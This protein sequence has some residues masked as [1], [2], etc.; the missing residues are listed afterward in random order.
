MRYMMMRKADANTEQGM[1]P[2]NE[3]LSDMGR[4]MAL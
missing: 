2:S 3:L 1:M 4:S